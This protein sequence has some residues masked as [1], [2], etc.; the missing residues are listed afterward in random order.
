[1]LFI[2][3]NNK[4]DVCSD[5]WSVLDGCNTDCVAVCWKQFGCE[6]RR[7]CK[8]FKASL[9]QVSLTFSL[10]FSDIKFL[11]NTSQV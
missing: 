5:G 11:P 8:N 7:T 3:N 9:E 6:T 4:H 10:F 1:M 2:K